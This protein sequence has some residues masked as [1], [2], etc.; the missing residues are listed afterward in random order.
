MARAV[1]RE[2]TW[3]GDELEARMRRANGRA[4]VGMGEMTAAYMSE[5]AH[6]LSGDLRRS[7]HA[8]KVET[9]GEQDATASNTRSGPSEWTVETGSWLP[10]ACVENNRGGEHRFAD[11][12]WQASRPHHDEVLQAAWREEGL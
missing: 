6:V 12:G 8:A 3:H 11:I 9:M 1:L 7:T 5:A 10:Y 4:V 2:R